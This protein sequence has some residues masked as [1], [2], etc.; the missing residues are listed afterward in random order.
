MKLL[1]LSAVIGATLLGA[2]PASAQIVIRERDDRIVVRD[3]D[4]DYNRGHHYGWR[5]HRAECG[6]VRERVTLWN[7]NVV[8]KTRQTC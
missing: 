8:Y 6:M 7:G 5:N 4:R 2:L 3:R 1:V